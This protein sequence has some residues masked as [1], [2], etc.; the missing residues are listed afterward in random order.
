MNSNRKKLPETSPSASV[1]FLTGTDS[2]FIKIVESEF[3]QCRFRIRREARWAVFM[4]ALGVPFFYQSDDGFYLP[5]QDCFLQVK[6]KEPTGEETKMAEKLARLT[7]TKVMLCFGPLETSDEFSVEGSMDAIFPPETAEDE[8][9]WD[10]PYLWCECP[11]CGRVGI[12]FEGRSDRIGCD[13]PK[14][15]HGDKGYNSDSARLIRAYEI[16]RGFQFGDETT[17]VM[18]LRGGSALLL[19]GVSGFSGAKCGRAGK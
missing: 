13:C 2:S 11:H 17:R 3:R 15:S 6:P 1:E 10:S 12:Q 16:A 9:G 14:S 18:S 5:D 4:Y 8:C 19:V 7:R